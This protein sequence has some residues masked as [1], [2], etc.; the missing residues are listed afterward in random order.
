MADWPTLVQYIRQ[1]YKVAE[2][3]SRILKLVFDT[4]NLRS[5]IL[6]VRYAERGT[7]GEEWV[8]LESPVG[9]T[10]TVDIR[11]AAMRAADY[12]CGGVVIEFDMVLLRHSVPLSDL[13]IHEFEAP[14]NVVVNGADLIESQLSNV[15]TY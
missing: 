2:E 1:N 12:V 6:F 15:D 14:M 5:Q 8:S 3:D 13:S 4:G 10:A 7:T 11:H 9:P